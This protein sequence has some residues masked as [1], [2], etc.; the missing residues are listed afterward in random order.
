MY[1]DDDAARKDLA[2]TVPG[3]ADHPNQAGNRDHGGAT[4]RMK[5]RE[6]LRLTGA[7]VITGDL[8]TR[9]GRAYPE[10]SNKTIRMAVVGGGFGATFHWHEHPNCVVTAVTDLYPERRERLR[11]YYR[12]EQVY[13]SLEVM[14]EKAHD[15]DAVAIFSGASDHAR[16]AKWCMERGWHVVSACPAVVSLEEAEML[17]ET[18]ERTG[19]RYMMAESSYYRQAC[20]FARNFHQQGGFGELFYSEVE[21]YH[22]CE[23]LK[24]VLQSFWAL[25]PDGSRSWRFGLPPMLYPTHSVGFL[26]GVTRERITKV[27][28]LGW[29]GERPELRDHPFRTEKTIWGDSPFW[30]QASMMLTDRGHM[31]RCN[32]FWRCHAHG[33]QARWFGENATLYMALSGVCPDVLDTREKGPAHNI[34]PEYWKTAEML[35]EPMRHPSGHGGSAVFISAEFINALL[36][37]RE[38]AIDLYESLAMTVPGIVAHQSALREGE[39]LPVPQFDPPK[40]A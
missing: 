40:K 18:K 4:G 2:S 21:Y 33:E 9:V 3:L 28:C 14:L 32:V 7:A 27:S 36:E 25:N 22:D 10:T 11:R 34:V 35:P 20:I 19:M 23:D 38:P 15:V 39:Q 24:T 26:V 6:F 29:R 13:E 37:D 1:H 17:K 8:L 31:C 16:H 30:S 12:C 5:R